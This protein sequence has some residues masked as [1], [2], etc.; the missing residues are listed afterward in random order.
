MA[1]CSLA[2][3]LSKEVIEKGR[4]EAHLSFEEGEGTHD[5]S[6]RNGAGP[7]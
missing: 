5:E 2:A 7:S 4:V 6:L 1:R 3:V